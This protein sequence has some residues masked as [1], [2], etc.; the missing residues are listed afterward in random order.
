[1]FDWK[2]TRSYNEWYSFILNFIWS[3]LDN[4]NDVTVDVENDA[5]TFSY[6]NV[7]TLETARK[8]LHK[9]GYPLVGED[10]KLPTKAKSYLSCAIGRMNN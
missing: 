1:M 6:D 4:I 3:E 9:L 2:V 5:V 7:D 8:Q 10:N